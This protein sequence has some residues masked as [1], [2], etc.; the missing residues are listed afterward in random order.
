MTRSLNWRRAQ[1]RLWRGE[2]DSD[3]PSQYGVRATEPDSPDVRQ[4]CNAFWLSDAIGKVTTSQL[5]GAIGG[6]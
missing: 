5:L 6:A 2:H 4:Q 1:E 3:I